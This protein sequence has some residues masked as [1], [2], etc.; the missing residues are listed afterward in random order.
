MTVKMPPSMRLVKA[1]SVSA[2]ML[3]GMRE[4]GASSA[5]VAVRVMAAV[6]SG[7]PPLP[8][9]TVT[10]M[11][12]GTAPDSAMRARKVKWRAA[13]SPAMTKSAASPLLTA[14]NGGCPPRTVRVIRSVIKPCR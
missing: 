14:E 3:S 10:V 1:T 4:I 7:A 2:P 5:R 12:A 6:L 11:A 8:K 13:K 9:A